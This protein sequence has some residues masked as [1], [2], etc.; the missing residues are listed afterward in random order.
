MKKNNFSI[1]TGSVVADIVNDNYNDLYETVKNTYIAHHKK[2]TI[3]PDSYFLR[4]PEKEQNRIIALPAHIGG[5]VNVSGIKWIASYPDNIKSGNQRASATLI[6]NDGETGYPFAFL[7]SSIISAV[8]T[9]ASAVCGAYYL[10]NKSKK[11]GKIGIIGCG[12]ISKNILKAF[13]K[14]NWEFKEI[15]I[16]DLN[17]EYA[18]SLKKDSENLYNVKIKIV[19]DLETIMKNEMIILATTAPSPYITDLS[20]VKH[21]PII[22]NISL[23]D[24]GEDII[25]N[26]NNFMDDIEHCLKANTSP[27]LAYLKLGHKDFINGHIGD[28]I[29]ETANINDNKPKIFSPFGLGVLDIAVGYYIYNKSI[30]LNKNIEIEDFFNTNVRW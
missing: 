25:E 24:I 9:S 7:E 30:K 16:Y 12:L 13:M 1:I 11:I 21:N 20:L 23:R 2:E 22:L 26:S 6:L 19:N 14:T 28:L 5:D 10:N 8:R 27:H 29:N 4:Y 15:E 18:E 3:N 17:K